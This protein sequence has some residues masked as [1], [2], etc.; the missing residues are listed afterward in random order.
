MESHGWHSSTRRPVPALPF[1]ALRS[2]FHVIFLPDCGPLEGVGP[3]SES[4]CQHLVSAGRCGVE[5]RVGGGVSGAEC[6]Q[7]WDSVVHTAGGWGTAAPGPLPSDNPSQGPFQEALG[8][9]KQQ[10]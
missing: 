2:L 10:M 7:V 1:W 9:V 4:Q 3:V 8:P 6:G 5:V